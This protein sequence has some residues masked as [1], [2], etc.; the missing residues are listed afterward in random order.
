MNLF[1]FIYLFVY[2][3]IDFNSKKMFLQATKHQNGI[4]TTN[5]LVRKEGSFKKEK[6]K[7]KN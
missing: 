7:K 3:L 5:I 6:K 1:L 2:L 4:P